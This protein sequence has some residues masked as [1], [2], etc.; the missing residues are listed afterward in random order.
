MKQ[1]RMVCL[2]LAAVFLLGMAVPASAEEAAQ[3]G[4]SKYEEGNQITSDC[5]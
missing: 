1:I 4:A 5:C 2:A 3:D